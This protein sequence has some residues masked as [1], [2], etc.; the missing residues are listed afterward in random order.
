MSLLLTILSHCGWSGT[1]SLGIIHYTLL[2]REITQMELPHQLDTNWKR[3]LPQHGHSGLVLSCKS[4]LLLPINYSLILSVDSF[5]S[6]STISS[7]KG[8]RSLRLSFS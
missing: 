5:Q 4:D 2:M 7:M 3:C 8:P 1:S 6:C